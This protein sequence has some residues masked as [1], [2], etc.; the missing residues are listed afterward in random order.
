MTVGFAAMQYEIIKRIAPHQFVT[1]NAFQD[2]TNVDL[3]RFV[4]EAVDFVS[5]DSYPEFKV[6]DPTLPRSFRDR[7]ES[8]L[9]SRMRGV[10]KFMVGA[11]IR[12]K[13]S[14]LS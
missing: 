6:C 10:S 1:H 5:Y 2:M 4:R 11:T 3:Q 7:S 8:R 9:L 14:N 12:A 13:R